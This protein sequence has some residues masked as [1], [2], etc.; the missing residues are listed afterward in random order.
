MKNIQSIT[1]DVVPGLISQPTVNVIKGDSETRYID[2][3]ALNTVSYTHLEIAFS[4]MK[5]AISAW[6]AE[7]KDATKE[8]SKT[9][10]AIKSAPD[11]SGATAIA[12]EAFGKKAG[13][14]LADAIKGGRFEVDE[15]IQALQSA[16][17]TVDNTYGAI[18]DEVDDSQLAMQRLKLAMHDTGETIAKSVGPV[19]LDL[20]ENIEDVFEW[21]GNL[22]KG[23]QQTLSLIHIWKEA[24]RISLPIQPER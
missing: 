4:G 10:D 7:G 6:S 19:L 15:Y 9:M 8:F 2:V 13:P 17:G 20:V 21:F 16:G 18:V 12:I 23:T 1:V 14:D 24:H 22:D 11:I 3:T 5:Q